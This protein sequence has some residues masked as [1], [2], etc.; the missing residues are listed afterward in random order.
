M[1]GGFDLLPVAL[2]FFRHAIERSNQIADF[3]GR[4]DID[5]VIQPAPGDFL[6]GFRQCS[7]RASYQF[8]QEQRQ[9]GRD[10]QDHHG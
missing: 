2:Q 1:A 4:T 9:P 5:A 10:K 7:Q 6:S 3:I 8:G